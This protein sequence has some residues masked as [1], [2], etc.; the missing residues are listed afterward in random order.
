MSS[1]HQQLKH[2][3]SSSLKQTNREK[4]QTNELLLWQCFLLTELQLKSF[5][6][7]QHDAQRVSM[8]LKMCAVNAA[9][10]PTW[11]R[12][13]QII[14]YRIDRHDWRTVKWVSHDRKW[15]VCHRSCFAA[16]QLSVSWASSIMWTYSIFAMFARQNS[17]IL[18]LINSD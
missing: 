5:L 3:D 4:Q 15:A 6:I 7:R 2:P 18:I 13:P 9:R 17:E 12:L 10:T 16:W 11:L 8:A 1:S 14:N